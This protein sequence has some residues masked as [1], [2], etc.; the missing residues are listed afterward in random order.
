MGLKTGFCDGLPIRPARDFAPFHYPGELRII[1]LHFLFFELRLNL[2]ECYLPIGEGGALVPG[3]KLHAHVYRAAAW[4]G[5]PIET[6]EATPHWFALDALPFDEMWADDRLW[7]PMMLAGQAF[8]A[9]F[10]FAD[11]RMLDHRFD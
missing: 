7:I 11:E 5:E 6:D 10:V 2:V 1:G 9:R 8:N 3:Y 4:E